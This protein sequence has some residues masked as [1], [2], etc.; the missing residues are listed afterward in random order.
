MTNKNPLTHLDEQGRPR[1][2][3]VGAKPETERVAVAKGAVYMQPQTMSL[4]LT[5]KLP[6]GDALQIARLAGLMGAKRT[7]ELIPLC[8]PLPLT[9]VE[10]DLTPGE[11]LADGRAR[12]VI[13]ATARCVGRTGV[14]MEA[15]TAVSV[16]AL[17]L[18]DMVKAVDRGIEIAEICLHQ[19]SGGKSGFWSR[20]TEQTNPC[21]ESKPDARDER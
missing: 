5:Q 16:A 12:I 2:V 10:V 21:V 6:K 20:N 19:K 3:D 18:Y 4:L 14:E 15:M 1:M 7:A 17:T 11:P 8:H 13:E 9:S